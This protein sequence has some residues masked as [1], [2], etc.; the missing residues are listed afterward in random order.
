MSIFIFYAFWIAFAFFFHEPWRDEAQAWLLARDCNFLQLLSQLKYEAH[1]V[2]WYLLIAPLA[3]AG[4]PFDAMRIFHGLITLACVG[5]ICFKIR[6]HF[7]IKLLYLFA[8][9]M[10]YEFASTARNYSIGILALLGLTL[11]YENRFTSKK[12]IFAACLFVLLNSNLY[13]TVVGIAIIGGEIF[14]AAYNIYEKKPAFEK[15]EKF[16]AVLFFSAAVI[17]FALIYLISLS[18]AFEKY[19]PVGIYLFYKYDPKKIFPS[20]RVLFETTSNALDSISGASFASV[21][22][23]AAFLF[24]LSMIILNANGLKSRLYTAL[25]AISAVFGSACL[26]SLTDRLDPYRHISTLAFFPLFLLNSGEKIAGEKIA[27]EKSKINENSAGVLAYLLIASICSGL[28]YNFSISIKDIKRPFS[29]NKQLASFLIENGYD[30]PD[31]M[32]LSTR[33]DLDS[34]IKAYMPNVGTFR[35]LENGI[36]YDLTYSPWQLRSAFAPTGSEDALS[37]A[38]NQTQANKSNYRAIIF[39]APL[40]NPYVKTCDYK[41]IFK[42]KGG[43]FDSDIDANAYIT[44]ENGVIMKEN[45]K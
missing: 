40:E 24:L 6:R 3:K 45:D 25:A 18:S 34:A 37:F 17:S 13:A 27:G 15:N 14:L 10:F 19:N 5:L 38:K 44:A 7:L 43:S 39:L 32:I 35:S 28:I 22:N 8:S 41:L 12:Y 23:G 36:P 2:M 21:T 4:A 16:G 33:S 1:P 11:C 31:V 20:F 30:A 29:E 42:S 26:Y 9:P